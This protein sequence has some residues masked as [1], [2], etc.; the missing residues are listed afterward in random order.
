MAG[1]AYS[2]GHVTGNLTL[3]ASVNLLVRGPATPE[4][5]GRAMLTWG[6]ALFAA[7]PVR[8][9]VTG[10]KDPLAVIDYANQAVTLSYIKG[11][12]LSVR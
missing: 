2:R 11:T 5:Q 12:M 10:E 9:S 1:G 4:A 6:G 7:S 3:P 8:W